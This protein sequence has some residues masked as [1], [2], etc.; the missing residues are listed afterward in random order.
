MLSDVETGNNLMLT[1]MTRVATL[2]HFHILMS[3]LVRNNSV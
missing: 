1:R 2:D 3:H